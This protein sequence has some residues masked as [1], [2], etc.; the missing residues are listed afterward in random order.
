[1]TNDAE[2]LG[3]A[4]DFNTFSFDFVCEETIDDI[5]KVAELADQRL[6]NMR[7]KLKNILSDLFLVEREGDETTMAFR[8]R[9]YEQFENEGVPSTNGYDKEDEEEEEPIQLPIDEVPMGC[10]SG[11]DKLDELKDTLK[12]I[13]DEKLFIKFLE[14]RVNDAVVVTKTCMQMKHELKGVIT[15]KFSEWTDAINEKS[16]LLGHLFA[17]PEQV[18]D[19]ENYYDFLNRMRAEFDA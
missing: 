10:A 16:A 6:I 17:D 19:G 18:E 15:E 7:M 9:L 8:N 1:M 13:D 4:L 5:E 14:P 11:Q 12:I 3:Y 2:D